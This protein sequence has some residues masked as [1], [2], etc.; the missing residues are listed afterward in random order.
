M[1]RT[2]RAPAARMGATGGESAR[3]LTDPH[4]VALRGRTP[5]QPVLSAHLPPPPPL[6][7]PLPLARASGRGM[8]VAPRHHSLFC[9]RLDRS[10]STPRRGD[11]RPSHTR[12]GRG[13][14]AAADAGRRAAPR[15]GTRPGRRSGW[16]RTRNPRAPQRPMPMAPAPDEGGQGALPSLALETWLTAPAQMRLRRVPAL[17]RRIRRRDRLLPHAA[18]PRH[19]GTR[20]IPLRPGGC[21]LHHGA[22]LPRPKAPC[23][24]RR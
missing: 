3:P 18:P 1:R 14:A 21:P 5:G 6:P 12:A 23:T 24:A 13:S 20:P 15:A 16:R 2:G 19:R 11:V 9:T 4:R 22:P 17:L 10:R 8:P 7:F